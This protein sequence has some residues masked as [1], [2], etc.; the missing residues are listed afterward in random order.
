MMS[1]QM[2]L[3]TI[4]I[5]HVTLRYMSNRC[6]E[7]AHD[8]ELI[9]PPALLALLDMGFTPTDAVATY[10]HL[11]SESPEWRGTRIREWFKNNWR[12]WNLLKELPKEAL[13]CIGLIVGNIIIPTG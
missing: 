3:E 5:T 12:D 1:E 4:A 8:I 7:Q 11:F 10:I 13:R 9:M 6:K 2:N